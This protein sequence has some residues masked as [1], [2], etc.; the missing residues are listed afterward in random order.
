MNENESPNPRDT[1][2]PMPREQVN[3]YV[4]QAGKAMAQAAADAECAVLWERVK[5]ISGDVHFVR[6]DQKRTDELALL[7]EY[8]GGPIDPIEWPVLNSSEDEY[9]LRAEYE[10]GV[11]PE[12]LQRDAAWLRERGI[13]AFFRQN[14]YELPW[15]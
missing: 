9:G 15:M 14:G 6:V 10:T 5:N 4:K 12:F 1:W 13:D 2:K 3:E 7:C 11:V 8:V